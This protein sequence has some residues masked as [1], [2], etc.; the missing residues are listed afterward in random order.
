MKKREAILR[1]ATDMFSRKPYHLVLMDEIAQSA[2]VAKGTL[3][4]HFNSKEDLF[5][6]LMQ[7]GLDDL[8][9]NLKYELKGKNPKE[10]LAIFF[11][12]LVRFFKENRKFFEVLKREEGRLLS[13]KTKNCYERI[14]SVKDLL[15]SIL[16]KG[17]NEKYFRDDLDIDTATEV[18]L[19]I[20]KSSVSSDR[21]SDNSHT[22]LFDIT[23]NGIKK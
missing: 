11:S 1:V 9:N 18:I 5:I 12:K 17:I 6:A 13:K 23:L 22:I 8:L 7:S 4:Y 2:G 3:Y 16:I 19:G 15:Q 20:I 21:F 14:C 10:N